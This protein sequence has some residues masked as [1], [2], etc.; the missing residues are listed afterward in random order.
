MEKLYTPRHLIVFAFTLL[1]F[2]TSNLVVN[3]QTTFTISKPFIGSNQFC[4]FNNGSNLLSIN[5]AFSS[6][7]INSTGNS[8]S[9]SIEISNDLGLIT[10]RIIGSA[11]P[12]VN[13]IYT[14]SVLVIQN[15]PYGNGY[16]IRIIT[17][18][19]S[20]FSAFS[21]PFAIAEAPATPILN[22]QAG[23]VVLCNGTTQ[24]L[25]VTNPSN[26]STY[27]WQNS[28]TSI[29]NATATS[30]A[31][32]SSGNYSVKAANSNGCT[33]SSSS[34]YF[35][36]SS[37]LYSNINAQ[38]S[39][40]YGNPLFV[41]PNQRFSINLSINGGKSPYNTTLS[42]GTT[43]ITNNN[44]NSSISY[45]L[46]APLSGS[47]I[48]TLS[49]LTDACGVQINNSASTK[50]R[51]NDSRYCPV[52]R[53]GTLGIKNFSIQGTSIS[54]LNSGKA[55]EGWGEYLNP[56]NINAN[57]NYNFSITPLTN[58]SQ[59]YFNIWADLN[60]NGLFDNNEKIFPTSAT[61]S[62]IISNT[63]TGTLK[64]PSTA[65]N[66][67][68]RLRVLLS[69]YALNPCD[70]SNEGEVEDY[71]LNI[72]NG[73]TPTIIATDSVPKTGVCIGTTF[74]VNFIVS[75]I[76]PPA[77]TSYQVEVSSDANFSYV[78]TI[79]TGQNSPI[80]CRTT[81][82][83]MSQPFYVR[84]VPTNSIPNKVIIPSPNQLFLKSIPTLNSIGAFLGNR[85]DQATAYSNTRSYSIEPSIPVSIIAKV[86][87]TPP[88]SVELS[89]GRIF[90]S[91]N[92]DNVVI[93]NNRLL[94][95]DTKFKVVRV[96]DNLCSI[97]KS[98]SVSIFVGTPS[99][100]IVKAI[101]N[102]N[103]TNAITKLCGQ[104]IVSF[105][106]RHLDTTSC[107]TYTVQISN[108][109]GSFANP[110]NIG[111][112]CRQTIFGESEGE[113]YIS[114]NIPSNFQIVSSTGYKLRIIKNSTNLTSPPFS[115]NFEVI[116]PTANFNYSLDKTIMNEGE[117]A[118]LNASF[119]GGT[120][121][122]SVTL[123][124]YSRGSQTYST[125][126]NSSNLSINLNPFYS[127]KYTLSYGNACFNY[128]GSNTQTFN[129]DVKT[130]DRSN[131]QWYIKPY[132]QSAFYELLTG[133]YLLNGTDT[134][135]NRPY[136]VSI[137][138]GIINKYYDYNSF[139]LSKPVSIISVGNNYS[140]AQ[141]SNSYYGTTSMLTGIWIDS[142]Q[143][144]DFDDVGEELAKNSF[145]QPWNNSQIQTFNIPNNATIGF[146]RLR[147]RVVIRNANQ[148]FTFNASNPIDNSADTYD[149]PIVILSNAIT[150]IIS[151]PSISGNTLCN[152]NSF[153]VDFAKYGVPAG[154]NANVELSDANGNF[155]A[156]PPIIGQG[157]NE[158]LNV[159][160]PMNITSGN[161]KIRVVSGGT[162][163][164][165]T[166]S[167]S[168][169]ANVLSSMVDG[170][171][172]A[173][174]TWSCGRVPTYMDDTTVS[175]GT[176]ITVFSGDANVGSIITNGVLSFLN[177]TQLRF[178][179]P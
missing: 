154:T 149:I 67:Q 84:V 155:T 141:I 79:G 166:P 64:L 118:A 150:S 12:N 179:T 124:T 43:N 10:P 114:C 81:L 13:V 25:T 76:A 163:S 99:L 131:G 96:A 8:I 9:H 95:N 49:N 138:Y 140:L 137:P 37:P 57:V 38:S 123:N 147:I 27:Q 130:Q 92:N 7:V 18:A 24:T 22:Q 110:T 113:N 46:T 83:N 1:F 161:Y 162:I 139:L 89:D 101:R 151:T 167:F 112:D 31:V 54:N 42:D 39:T 80:N 175:I 88:F 78:T 107:R 16:R 14:G 165:P 66:G 69:N 85:T 135:F 143:D 45:N 53:T 48:Y 34:I 91:N 174:S 178:R 5:Y 35:L 32:N 90:T 58:I 128:I 108:E 148:N 156:S 159:T 65:F 173:G 105:T 169:T 56:A 136:N 115:T 109:N 4:Y 71:V 17:T 21:D 132:Q 116:S 176:N 170:D 157:T 15:L 75:G 30:Y 120:S 172:H 164:P 20:V 104:F 3:A 29:A 160:L 111:Y 50:I 93:E 36:Q 61:T 28:G 63:Y 117:T 152:G 40:A 19:P 52:A 70:V 97:S 55:Q 60:Q 177:G 129:L 72:F 94:T 102:Y 51:V 73:I 125:A 2:I 59:Q 121:P 122:Y 127:E 62:Q 106:G 158:S 142:N 77:N 86:Y 103:D 153:N 26:T 11:S 98:D 171:W 100:K 144:G 47:K 33:V 41:T 44:V 126:L 168:V 119:S 68:T 133:T 23:S 134:L 6:N 145:S 82:I 146:S 74:P 87:G